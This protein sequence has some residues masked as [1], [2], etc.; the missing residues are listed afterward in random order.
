MANLKVYFLVVLLTAL[1][2]GISGLPYNNISESA[3]DDS[4]RAQALL[5]IEKY[6]KT[7]L[8]VT[9]TD[10]SGRAIQ[11]AEVRFEMKRA[12][13]QFGTAV[14][15]R[16]MM[17]DSGTSARFQQ[18]IAQYFNTIVFENDLKWP[19][20]QTSQSNA[21][22]N[23]RVTWTQQAIQWA[24]QR[25]IDVRGHAMLWGSW[26][27]SP[28][29]IP[30][31]PVGLSNAIAAHVQDI[32][33]RLSG[34]LV[35]WDVLNEPYSE[36]DFT[37][38]LGRGAMIDWFRHARNADPNAKLFLNDYPNPS[39]QNFIN[40]DAEC[41]RLLVS[42]GASVQAFG[43]QGH[44]GT[45]PWNIGQYQNM[46]N[47]FANTGVDLAVTEYDTEISNEQTDAQALRDI[48]TATF[49][50]PRMTS[51]LVW[52][53]WD[54]I[55]WKGRA[56]FFRADWS[57]KP[58]LQVWRDLTRNQWWSDVNGTTSGQGTFSSRVFQGHY[59]IHI[60]HGGKTKIVNTVLDN[61]Q[62]T[63]SMSIVI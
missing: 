10:S 51:F 57:E 15:V 40:F 45:S 21:D 47:T 49:A 8:H 41:L 38:L 17:I 34:Q 35:H 53:F 29:D 7:D 52:G 9:V 32:G 28:N 54:S 11:D 18:I 25:N 31:D 46:M 36:N 61:S 43:I 33:S 24:R 3:D 12:V 20:W 37:N 42:S 1:C 26:R 4:W 30:R 5:D 56:P 19:Q 48:M 59:D 23:H 62:S 22:V 14:G 55:H 44:V 27:W 16:Q 58:A 13:F 60:T 2:S 50:H 6:R 63:Q 39:D